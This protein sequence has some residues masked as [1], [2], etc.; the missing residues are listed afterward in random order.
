MGNPFMRSLFK[1]ILNTAARN[2]YKMRDS[3]Q[4]LGK[5]ARESGKKIYDSP[6]YKAY[7]EAAKGKAGPTTFGPFT[8]GK[9]IKQ[10]TALGTPIYAYDK[11][12]DLTELPFRT[13]TPEKTEEIVTQEDKD[14]LIE[15]KIENKKETVTEDIEVKEEVIATSEDTSNTQTTDTALVEQ[16]N[17]YSGLIDNDSLRRIDGYK[18][19]IKQ[20]MGSGDESQ[21]M[22]SMA[23][24]MQLGSALMSGKT[25]DSGLKGF[26]DVVGQAGM[27]AAPT[28]FQMG[29]EKGKADREIGAAALNMYMSELDKANDR[30]G[31]FTIVYENLYKT[32]GNN[33][34]VYDGNGDM[35]SMDKR[36]VGTYYRKSPEISSYMD[37]NSGSGYDRFTFVDTTASK[38]GM[39]ASGWGTGTTAQMGGEAAKDA[40]IK[41]ANY[42][43]RGIN[44]MADFIMPL[45]IDQRQNLLGTWGEIARLGAPKKA[46][47]DAITQGL[48]TSAGGEKS[49]NE[50]FNAI[51]NDTLDA[52]QKDNYLVFRT[53]N[54]SQIIDG[55]E[56]GFFVDHKNEYGFNANP[57]YSSDGKTLL[58][59]GEAAWIPTRKG[60]EMLLDNPNLSALKTF[61]TTLGLM[62]ARDRQPT[63]R[64][65]ADVLRNS[66]AQTKMTGLGSDLATSPQQV[67]E[68]Y[69]Y[70]YN[71]LYDNMTAA[72]KSA[73]QTD[74]EAEAMENNWDFVPESFNVTG[75]DKFVSSYYQLRYGDS[76]YEKEIHGAS[77]YGAWVQSMEANINL[78]SNETQQATEEIH[79]NIME[80]LQ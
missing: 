56:V 38:E 23:M 4:E 6:Y 24:L 8:G 46:F 16:A 13:T 54:Q 67:I 31:P 2:A 20:I 28:L 12:S 10:I 63:G 64:M 60:I 72:Y 26:M 45:I 14:V 76:R 62:L 66:F 69:V 17:L 5:A 51:Q 43:K 48:F 35:I 25:M 55:K 80:S 53:P 77:M 50:K 36:R 44:T 37:M 21:N 9:R 47:I 65:L 34:F 68:N 22:Q 27:Q 7:V 52:M 33:G 73:G 59:P 39:Q 3:A 78:D 61:E 42:L 15:D 58:D 32:D 19:V 41:Y 40:Q 71:T 57:T 29:V 74:N 30:S 1:P 49:F 70:I 11:L 18:D 79:Q 75:I